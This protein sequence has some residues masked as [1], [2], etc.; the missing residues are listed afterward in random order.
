[1]S[2]GP[3]HDPFSG[4][5]TR[6]I[7]LHIVSPKIVNDGSGGYTVKTDL[8][9]ID[10]VYATG[11][12]GGTLSL[13]GNFTGKSTGTVTATNGTPVS[14]ANTNVTAN[15]IILLTVKT[16][17]GT[18]AG[19]AY[20]SSTTASTGFSITSGASDTSVYNYMILN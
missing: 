15:S 1:M 19:Q 5:N 16:A 10:N 4:S 9:N 12:V 11:F 14:V 7:L 13:T 17:T 20:V 3:G 6:N 18:N 2:T 8:I